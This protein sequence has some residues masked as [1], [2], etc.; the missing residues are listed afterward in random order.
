[1]EEIDERIERLGS[2][3]DSDKKE[4]T[5]YCV[6]ITT[7][8]DKDIAVRLKN[9]ALNK[10]LA[11][12]VN[13]IEGVSSFYWWKSEI[14]ESEEFLLIFKT[15]KDL[16]EELKKEI[17][18]AHNY[19]IAEFIVLPISNISLHYADWIDREVKRHV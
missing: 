1:M 18:V 2:A 8:D 17:L 10:R 14:E 16:V 19:E 15:R 4:W 11:A 7:T 12:C 9:I 6:A 13:I 3:F 5:E